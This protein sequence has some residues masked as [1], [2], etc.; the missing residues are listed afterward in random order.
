MGKATKGKSHNSS[1]DRQ[2]FLSLAVILFGAMAGVLVFLR[3]YDSYIGNTL[4]AE[5]LNQM[6]EVTTQ[7]FSGLEDVIENQWR[8]VDTQCRALQQ[9]QPSTISD[10]ISFMDNQA[11]LDDLDNIQCDVFAVDENGMYYT[12][13]GRQGLLTE[14]SY[15]ASSR[16]QV[17]FVSDSLTYDRTR[18]IF[19]RKLSQPI[20]MQNGLETVTL[21]YFGIAQDMSELDPYFEC[22]AYSGHSSVYVIDENGQKLFH[23]SGNEDFLRGYNVFTTLRSMNYLHGSS[24]DSTLAELDKNGIAYYCSGL[25]QCCLYFLAFQTATESCDCFG[26][27]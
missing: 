5:R 19:L 23:S 3:F 13:D 7:L 1:L 11:Y 21:S 16:E 24:F 18:M 9:N 12:Q 27:V 8:I 26:T 4:Y 17:S 22:S 15:L 14:R 10:L 25:C 6:R 2:S 20:I